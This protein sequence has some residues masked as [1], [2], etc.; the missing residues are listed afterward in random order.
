MED[1]STLGRCLALAG[2][3]WVASHGH[4]F[5]GL[6]Q[7]AAELPLCVGLRHAR[8]SEEAPALGDRSRWARPRR[9]ALLR[10]LLLQETDSGTGSPR[11]L[12][13]GSPE[14]S[15]LR[16]KYFKFR[17]PREERHF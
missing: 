3:N 7:R 5:R 9:A 14:I 16:L 17:Q 2:R 8:D 13:S 10:A 15:F 4:H 12:V 11:T 6:A 1:L